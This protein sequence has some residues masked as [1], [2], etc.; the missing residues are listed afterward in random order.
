MD[1]IRKR[2]PRNLNES[3]KRKTVEVHSDFINIVAWI[4]T[5]RRYTCDIDP[6]QNNPG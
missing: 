1:M 6:D 4:Y 5:G 2:L 3:V